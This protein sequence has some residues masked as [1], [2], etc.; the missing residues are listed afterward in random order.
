MNFYLR[1]FDEADLV[2]CDRSV[3]DP[4][5]VGPFEWVGFGVPQQYRRRWTDDRLLGS[6]PYNLVVA[7]DGDAPIGWV[8]W[9]DTERAG[10]GAWEIGV[11][12]VPEMRGRGAGTAAH[13]LVVDYLFATTPAHRIWAGTEVDN[14]AE[15]RA[16]E[17]SGFLQE[18]LLRGHHFRGGQWRDSFIYGITRT[19]YATAD[20]VESSSAARDHGRRHP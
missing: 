20:D 5:F 4:D 11:L 10:P 18:G 6:S 9:R 3:T 17:R 1:P 8:N 12:I 14:I 13:R 7:D 19:D 16:L 15:Q 2:M